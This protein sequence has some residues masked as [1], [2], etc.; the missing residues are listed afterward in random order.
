[1]GAGGQLV[2]QLRRQGHQPAEDLQ[3]GP[4]QR[5]HLRSGDLLVGGHLDAGHQVRLGREQVPHT[6]ALEALDHEPH[7]AVG[8]ARE[9]MDDAGGA[10]RMQVVEAG[11]LLLRVALRH[12]GQ[13]PVAAH[14]VVD[15]LDRARLRDGQRHRRLRK[16]NTV[17]QRQDR[18]RVR[19]RYV[20]SGWHRHQAVAPRLGKVIRSSPRS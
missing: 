18:Q 2:R 4:A 9:L 3:H 12:E 6:Y 8:G 17:A 11:R 1:V 14:D 15:E 10:D 7:A 16:D 20:G 19:N 5:V 13:H